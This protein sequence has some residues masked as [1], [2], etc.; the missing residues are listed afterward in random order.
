MVSWLGMG[1][2]CKY[3][4]M[5]KKVVQAMLIYKEFSYL[6]ESVFVMVGLNVL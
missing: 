1:G 2:G 6:W 4:T 5:P 3:G